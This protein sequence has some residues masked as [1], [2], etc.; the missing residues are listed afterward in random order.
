MVAERENK[1]QIDFD[2]KHQSQFSVMQAELVNQIAML[3]SDRE[4]MKQDWND[5]TS[6]KDKKIEILRQRFLETQQVLDKVSRPGSSHDAPVHTASAI[7]IVAK[8]ITE[9]IREESDPKPPN[10]PGGDGGCG[11]GDGGNPGD[12]S[13]PG[14][15]SQPVRDEN[16][17]PNPGNPGSP[18]DPNPQT[19]PGMRILPLPSRCGL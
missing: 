14:R 6:S 15:A 12:P 1:M 18:N 5:I 16:K 13:D 7:R 8:V 2:E 10:R 9:T 19:T 4:R 3:N 17:K 11:G